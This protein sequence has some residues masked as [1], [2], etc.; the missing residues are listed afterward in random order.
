MGVQK[1]YGLQTFLLD[2]FGQFLLLR[3][4]AATRIY[5]DALLGIVI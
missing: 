5:N 3:T 4:V 2:E 1:F